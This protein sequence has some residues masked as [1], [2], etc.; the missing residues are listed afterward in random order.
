[1]CTVSC[2]V[3]CMAHWRWQAHKLADHPWGA[4]ADN[5]EWALHLRRS[6]ST[7]TGSVI[8]CLQ[9]LDTRWA[10]VMRLAAGRGHVSHCSDAIIGSW[11][12]GAPVRGTPK[13]RR[14]ASYVPHST[15]P[16]PGLRLPLA[17]AG[18]EARQS[19]NGVQEGVMLVGAE[20]SA[21]TVHGQ[22]HAGGFQ[23]AF[24]TLVSHA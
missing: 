1:M 11:R 23:G 21:M 9:L 15:D 2:I 14:Y 24:A 17:F 13:G 16:R 12:R 18:D 19:G 5:S 7:S 22:W 8:T 3:A 6:P 20:P 10:W 4:H